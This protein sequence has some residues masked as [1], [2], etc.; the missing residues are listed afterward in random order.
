[1]EG[2]PVTYARGL[3]VLDVGGGAP[4]V[5]VPGYTGSKEDFGPLLAP[6]AVA[7]HR[8]IGYDQ[9]GQFQS[10][11][12]GELS[13]YR[14]GPLA[15]DLL[16]LLDEL[17]LDR[18]HLIGHSYGGL[19]A[20]AALLARPEAFLSLA[21]I[22]S[23]PAALAGPRAEVT[24]ALR[25]TLRSGGVPAVWQLLEAGGDTSAFGRERFL[26]QDRVALEGMG[27]ALL[28][29]PDRVGELAEV[30]RRHGIAVLVACGEHDDAWSPQL[31]RVMAARLGARFQ[32][33]PAAA[34]SPAVEAPDSTAAL[35]LDF[36]RSAAVAGP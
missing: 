14:P 29:E 33:I 24:R 5:C 27:E 18:V 35:L 31:Q 17:G 16:G 22:G 25:A 11:G 32:L 13:S 6:L 28:D 8:V 15:G 23:G 34:H 12:H 1:V 7:G 19:V 3:A 4:I 21:L 9:R 10:P 26:A 2:L 36:Y 20:R 30:C